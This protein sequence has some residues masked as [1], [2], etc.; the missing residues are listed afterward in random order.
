M[1]RLGGLTLIVKISFFIKFATYL[2]ILRLDSL[3]PI[4]VHAC[5]DIGGWVD[6]SSPF[7]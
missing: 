5:D 3:T 2:K 1:L 6:K 7:L 4:L